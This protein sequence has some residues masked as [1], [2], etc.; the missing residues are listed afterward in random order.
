MKNRTILLPMNQDW[1]TDRAFME[2][3]MKEVEQK[4]ILPEVIK[5]FS[6]KL[7]LL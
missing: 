3:Y 1:K 2:Q 7:S 6:N 5:Y 4:K